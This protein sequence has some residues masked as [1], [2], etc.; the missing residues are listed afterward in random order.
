MAGAVQQQCGSWEQ[1]GYGAF[2][3]AEPLASPNLS[4]VAMHQAGRRRLEELP[5]RMDYTE[6]S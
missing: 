6:V 1:R 2:L 3:T 5:E 4:S